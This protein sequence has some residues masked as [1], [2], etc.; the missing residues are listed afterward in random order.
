MPEIPESEKKDRAPGSKRFKPLFDL[1]GINPGF[2]MDQQEKTVTWIG[3]VCSLILF[4]CL[5]GVIIFYFKILVRNEGLDVYNKVET[6]AKF[7]F[8]DL[9]EK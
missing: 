3:F 9:K 2:Y 4:G 7:P 8:V 5:A 6:L 1:Y